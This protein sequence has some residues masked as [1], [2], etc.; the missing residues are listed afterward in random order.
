MTFLNPALWL[1][2]LLAGL[3]I[4]IHLLGRR[5][6]KKQ[7]FPTLEFLKKLQSKRMRKLKIRQ[8]ILL[9]IRTLA[10]LLIAL[11]FIRPTFKSAASGNG[12]NNESVILLDLSASMSA[13]RSE[14]TPI[15]KARQTISDII[16]AGGK[17]SVLVLEDD[18]SRDFLSTSSESEKPDWLENI[19]SDGRNESVQSALEKAI[20]ILE[21]SS[22]TTREII[23]LSDFTSTPIDTLSVIPEGI[24][25]WRVPL[26]EGTAMNATITKADIVDGVLRKGET[27]VFECGFFLRGSNEEI[28]TVATISIDGV[29]VAEGE[30]LLTPGQEITQRF[31]IKVPEKGFHAGE[32][33]FEF[34]DAL[35]LDN[36]YPFVL[37]VPDHQKILIA[38]DDLSAL[39]LLELGLDPQLSGSAFE[40]TVIPRGL[41]GLNLDEFDVL[42]LAGIR[43]FSSPVIER[44]KQFVQDGGGLWLITGNQVDISRYNRGILHEL[45]I[46]QILGGDLDQGVLQSWGDI[47]YNHP[48]LSSI[49]KGEK[50]FDIPKVAKSFRCQLDKKANSIIYLGNGTPFLVEK[51]LGNGKI[52]FTPVAVDEMWTDWMYSGIFSPMVQQGIGYL[53]GDIVGNGN[54]FHCGETV[55]WRGVGN[56]INDRMVEVIDPL[57]NSIPA[58]PGGTGNERVIKSEISRWPGHYKLR[59]NGSSDRITAVT[60]PVSETVLAVNEKYEWPGKVIKLPENK[61]FTAT[62]N[63]AR[64]GKEITTVL[65][66]IVLLLMIAETLIARE[67]KQSPNEVFSVGNER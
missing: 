9:I 17:V 63:K 31:S 19:S 59:A 21:S 32:V 24:A 42:L 57:N 64:Y 34:T 37:N 55:I 33:E 4:L 58:I 3:P 48:A 67:S 49:L 52:W 15:E 29:R 38:G 46:G 36:R 8:L 25:L 53:A 11:A 44:L 20:S 66:I 62:L 22:A 30:I 60:L 2:L 7:V 13:I 14:G 18:R 6:L 39:R 56:D 61:S 27:V 28:E 45:K 51:P 26:A 41:D 10:V 54:G 35:A 5:R 1:G 47:N 40:I 50:R 16:D 12:G 43:S 23:W 65:I